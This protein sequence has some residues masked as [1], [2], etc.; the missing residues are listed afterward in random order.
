[1]SKIANAAEAWDKARTKL[2]EAERIDPA[3][4]P[5]RGVGT[6]LSPRLDRA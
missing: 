4:A 2:R 3:A 6:L 1:M 5:W